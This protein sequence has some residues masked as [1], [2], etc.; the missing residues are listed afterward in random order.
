MR[1]CMNNAGQLISGTQSTQSD[2]VFLNNKSRAGLFIDLS[3]LYL[4]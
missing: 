4:H 1:Q 3:L 2:D